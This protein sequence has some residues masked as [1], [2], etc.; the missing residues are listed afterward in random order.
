MLLIVGEAIAAYSREIPAG[1]TAADPIPF[2]GPFASGA[3]AIAAYVAAQLGAEVRL[4]AGVGNDR[5][6]A[7]L[8]ERLTAAGVHTDNLYEYDELPTATVE[9]TYF[10]DGTRSFGFQVATTAATRI[11][12]PELTDLPEQAAWLHLSGSALIFGEPL[13]STALAALRRAHRSGATVSVDPNLRPD[14]LDE[15]TRRLLVDAIDLAS[16]VFPS[17]GEL[18]ALGLDATALADSGKVVCATHGAAGA[19]LLT[20]AG[21]QHVPAPATTVVDADGAGDTFAGGYIAATLAGA[22]PARAAE[23]AARA[24]AESIAVAGP[25]EA[26]LTRY[27]AA[28]SA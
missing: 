12:E 27:P 14:S 5:H 21:R 20:A 2:A 11:T 22:D 10:A 8:R 28:G 15:P 24:C 26:T 19:D 3:P 6:G 17:D 7:V 18:E 25:M 9:I 23:V 4:V 13:R 1:G 16:V